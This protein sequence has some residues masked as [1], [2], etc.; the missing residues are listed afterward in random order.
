MGVPT[1]VPRRYETGALIM[2]VA[3]S[4][5]LVDQ[6]L[7]NSVIYEEY[8]GNYATARRIAEEKVAETRQGED[9]VA[10]N[11]ALL[12]LGVVQIL[13]GETSAARKTFSE[14]EAQ[15]A[16][17]PALELRLSGYRYLVEQLH[18]GTFP[19]NTSASSIEI[20]ARG[21]LLHIAEIFEQTARR[22]ELWDTVADSAMRIERELLYKLSG[23]S[24]VFRG[25]LR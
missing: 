9:R 14:L 4:I 7:G 20:D 25:Y 16:E 15:A 23:T 21:G 22:Q 17:N 18:L 10:G 1:R 11:D 5:P 2:S 6:A 19:D 13:Q 24:R 8:K 12:A 3:F